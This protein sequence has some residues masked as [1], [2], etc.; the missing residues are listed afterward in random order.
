MVG[1]FWKG[2]ILLALSS[3]CEE[4]PKLDSVALAPKVLEQFKK[5]DNMEWMINAEVYFGLSFPTIDDKY[6]IQIRWA[7][8]ELNFEKMVI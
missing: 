8:V 2:R 3:A 1:S 7:D 6:Y 4:N 5:S